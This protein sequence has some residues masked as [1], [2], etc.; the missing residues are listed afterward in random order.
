MLRDYLQLPM[1]VRVLCLGSLVNRAGSFVV[2]FLTLYVSEHLGFGVPFATL[3]MGVFGFGSMIGSMVGGQ[4]AD[5]LGRRIVMLLALFGGSAVLLLMGSISNPWLFM[6]TVGVFGLV[7]DMY[8]PAA[9]A[10]IADVVPVARRP[11]AFALMY[12]SVNL[13]FA[14]API[15]GG[16]LAEYSFTLLFV[17]DAL[18]M[19]LYGL[20]V[21]VLVRETL[22]QRAEVDRGTPASQPKDEE[23]LLRDAIQ[24]MLTDMPFVMFCVAGFLCSCV[25]MQCISTL[26]VYIREA[27]F[28]HS[29][30]GTLMSINGVLIVLLQ[31]P[32]A[33]WTSRFNAMSVI[34]IGSSLVA[35]GFGSTGFWQRIPVSRHH[36][37]AV[38]TGGDPERALSAFHRDGFSARRFAGALFGNVRSVR[39][40]F[41]DDRRSPGRRDPDSFRFAIFVGRVVLRRIDR[42]RLLPRFAYRDHPTD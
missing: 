22:P 42:D 36:R 33:H 14:I 8:R 40:L 31:L 30:F 26:P 39:R 3:C 4:L 41:A 35:V 7:M 5:Q 16:F 1:L 10:M 38:D 9:S 32:A 23:V 15:V 28:S 21:S 25:F 13:G 2:I 6:I 18:T 19:S 24:T 37:Y 29:Q 17:V 27:G 12:I 20:I 34:V 11:H